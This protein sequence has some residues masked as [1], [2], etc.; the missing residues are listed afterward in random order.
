MP[1]T[2]LQ[3]TGVRSGTFLLHDRAKRGKA[4]LKFGLDQMLKLL[5]R[6]AF[7]P[8]LRDSSTTGP[9][10]KRFRRFRDSYRSMNQQ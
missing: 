2:Q 4:V 6:A 1:K 10:I 5:A 3:Q 9:D 7:K 8:C